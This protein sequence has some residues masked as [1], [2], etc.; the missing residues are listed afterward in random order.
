MCF[1]QKSLW[2]APVTPSWLI[3]FFSN[4]GFEVIKVTISLVLEAN[5]LLRSAQRW[6]PHRLSDHP[7]FWRTRSLGF[8]RSICM[9]NLHPLHHLTVQPSNG[10]A[11]RAFSWNT[12]TN[13]YELTLW[14]QQNVCNS[15]LIELA[16]RVAMI[17]ETIGEIIRFLEMSFQQKRYQQL[18]L[19]RRLMRPEMPPHWKAAGVIEVQPYAKR[20][21]T[22]PSHSTPSVI[23]VRPS[24]DYPLL[25]GGENLHRSGTTKTTKIT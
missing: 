16:M 15:N 13:F 12:V 20:N 8:S 2:F 10:W 24:Q 1:W 21:Y 23:V 11:V 19:W 5:L 22:S 9:L 4:F 18:D 25:V 14:S 6:F 7:T 17:Y 3:A